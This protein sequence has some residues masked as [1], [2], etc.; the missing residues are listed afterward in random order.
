MLDLVDEALDQ[1][2]LFVQMT[3]MLA[4][5]VATW[6]RGNDRFGAALNNQIKE[7][8]RIVGLVGDDVVGAEALDECRRLRNIVALTSC[9]AQTKRIAQAIDADMNLG[10]E[11][12]TTASQGLLSLTACFFGRQRRKDGRG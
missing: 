1:V 10:A 2:A 11:A 5:L 7:I 3:V 6:R 9:E 4:L 8:S 12:A